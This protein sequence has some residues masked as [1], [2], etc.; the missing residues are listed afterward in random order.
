M[1]FLVQ[2]EAIQK[3]DHPI[4]VERYR[5]KNLNDYIGNDVVKET[6]K[7]FVEKQDLPHLLFFGPAGTG[8]TSLAKILTSNISCDV[9]Y[10]NASAENRVDDVRIKLKNFASGAGF[11]PL[12]VAI[13]DE[14][15]R[16]T[17]E[18]QGALRNMME[19]Y[20]IHTR[21]ILTCNYFEKMIAPIVSR[22]QTFEIKPI[23]KSDI[24]RKLV[25]VLQAEAVNFT[26]EDIKFIVETYY[27]DI[28]KVINFAQQSNLNGTLKIC[29]ENAVEVDFLNKLIEILKKPAETSAFTQ[30]RQL[31]VEIDPNS[32][33]LIY[34][35][36]LD[37]VDQYAAG[38]EAI[39]ILRL[40]EA[41]KQSTGLISNVR[42]IPF[43]AC[44]YN[45]LNDLKE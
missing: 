39:I 37:K 38:K 19:T 17:P 5:P 4:W 28:R 20:S 12:K 33:E 24:A 27:P 44:V 2:E 23:S 15:D 32:L 25:N 16:L 30:I 7:I 22:C 36:L 41:L 45:I 42:D 8:K 18:A 43:L 10:V 6:C 9:L 13:L 21:F 31:V 40:A 14:S 29:K 1:D 26:K 11:K 34:R 35:H 3:K